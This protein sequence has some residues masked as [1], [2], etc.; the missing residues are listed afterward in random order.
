MSIGQ[1]SA[2]VL[3]P[4]VPKKISIPGACGYAWS[5]S[6]DGKQLL[7]NCPGAGPVHVFRSESGE[8]S[9]FL[10]RQIYHVSFSPDSRW[11]AFGQHYPNGR[12][13][14]FLSPFDGKTAP[15][16]QDW[17][18]VTDGATFDAYP[19]W[20][21]SG[22]FLYFIS[23]RDGFRC[24]W[25]QRLDPATKRLLGAPA[26]VF[27]SHASRRSLLNVGVNSL[28]VSVARDKIALPIGEITGNIWMAKL[29]GQR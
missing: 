3:Q 23:D 27:H 29:P 16:E 18:P 20:S 19:G 7:Y 15:Q 24:L 6:S 4:G 5:W 25:A 10:G 22:N 8:T 26:P 28:E 17:L 14:V 2:G 21:P 13:R 1:D 11:I 12:E 9:Q